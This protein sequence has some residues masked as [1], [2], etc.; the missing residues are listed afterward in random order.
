MTD[1][2][3]NEVLLDTLIKVSISEAFE[4]EMAALPSIEELDEEYKPSSEL[5]KRINVIIGKSYRK[6]KM[7]GLAKILGK[8]A[9]CICIVFTIS[10]VVLLSVSATRN[11]IFNAVIQWQGKYTEVKFGDSATS[12]DTYRPTYLLEG[13]SENSTEEFGNTVMITY[14]NEAGENIT[15]SQ[16]VYDTGT[17]LVDNQNTNYTETEISGNKAYLFKAQTG[18]D[19]N[20]LIWQSYGM[21]F[22]LNSKVD[23][24]QLRHIGESIKK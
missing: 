17:S 23:S 4:K 20:I 10:S 22:E 19:S 9:A 8:V 3:K 14:S 16:W 7:R 21:V 15:F 12:N 1:K 18:D 6:A 5:D 2:E 11:A 13:F 24:D